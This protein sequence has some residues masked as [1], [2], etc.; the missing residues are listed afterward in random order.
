MT[1]RSI[2]Q[3][4]LRNNIGGVLREAESG[5]EF[6]I[7]VRGRPVA[8]LGPLDQPHGRR[9]DVDVTTIRVML[10]DTPVDDQFSSD[11]A[12]MRRDEQPV[13]DSWLHT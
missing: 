5:A 6:T 7:T 13:D 8:R 4:E 3:R 10:A 11:L 1:A 12:K 2:P 9:V